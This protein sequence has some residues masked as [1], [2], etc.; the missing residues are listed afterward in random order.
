MNIKNF[1]NIRQSVTI[2]MLCFF[3]VYMK[4]KKEE[5]TIDIDMGSY[6]VF[7]HWDRRQYPIDDYLVSNDR[8]K[9]V[10]WT[11]IWI[12]FKNRKM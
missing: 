4:T 10:I 11:I 6:L 3:V 2:S 9:N 5:G 7:V 12:V 1:E 8:P